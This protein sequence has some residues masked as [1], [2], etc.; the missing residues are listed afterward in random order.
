MPETRSRYNEKMWKQSRK[1]FDRHEIRTRGEGRWTI[2]RRNSRP[3]DSDATGNTGWTWIMGAEI[4][5]MGHQA[6]AVVGDID[7]M[8]FAHGGNDYLRRIFWMGRSTSLGYIQ[9][10][11]QIG[12]TSR[13]L[14]TSYEADVARSDLEYR[15]RERLGELERDDDP[16][17]EELEKQIDKEVAKLLGERSLT[18]YMHDCEHHDAEVRAYVET[19]HWYVEDGPH[20]VFN[21][22]YNYNGVEFEAEYICDIG[23]VIS[24]RVFY[25]HAAVARLA[26]LLAKESENDGGEGG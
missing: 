10:K 14:V 23:D 11:A 17:D 22:L 16:T 21:H 9:E 5:C 24:P 25:A 2:Q 4:V 18:G 3:E 12:T 19:Y 8:V 6:I 1:A 13:E 7:S 15:I 20:S 26:E